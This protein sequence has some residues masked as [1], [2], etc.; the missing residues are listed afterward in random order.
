MNR[1]GKF[2][3]FSRNSFRRLITATPI[4]I[5]LIASFL[6]HVG[7]LYVKWDSFSNKELDRKRTELTVTSDYQKLVEKIRNQRKSPISKQQRKKSQKRQIVNNELSGKELKPDS[8]R[9]LG[10][11]NQS[12]D[13][14]TV[15]NKIGIFKKAGVGD[16]KGLK[17]GKVLKKIAK[18]KKASKK[19]SLNDLSIKNNVN[20]KDFLAANKKQA[21]KG[22]AKE[23]ELS[24]LGIKNGDLTSTG[25]SRNNDYVDDLPLGDFT[26]LNTQEFKYYGFYHRIRQK[27]E[28]FWGNSLRAKAK[29]IYRSGRRMPSSQN[30]ITSLRI[31]IDNKGNIVKV[32]VQGSSGVRELDEAAIESF[33]KAGPFPNP[34]RGMLSKGVATIEWGFVVKS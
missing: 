24:K 34:P 7:F 9:F 14:Q 4:Q 15:A 33:N 8:D 22:Q 16:R 18:V 1:I 12:Y 5:A 23:L 32:H 13:R 28:Q 21:D 31:S 20:A 26:R 10:E 30:L 2:I 11:K 6:F 17:D 3:E 19:F 29:K 25:L 27:L